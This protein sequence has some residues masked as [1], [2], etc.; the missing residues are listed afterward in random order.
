VWRYRKLIQLDSQTI[1]Q[2][3]LDVARALISVSSWDFIDKV[4]DIKVGNN[5]FVVRIIEERFGDI[6]L[7]FKREIDSQL[8]SD[9]SVSDNSNFDTDGFGRHGGA[10]KKNGGDWNEGWTEVNPGCQHQI[11]NYPTVNTAVDSDTSAKGVGERDIEVPVKG[12]D[13]TKEGMGTKAR[14]SQDEQVSKKKNEGE[15]V[16]GV[17][18]KGEE[19]GMLLSALTLVVGGEQTNL[20]IETSEEGEM[21]ARDLVTQ[22]HL[23][24]EDGPRETGCGL[25]QGSN[26]NEIIINKG[27]NIMLEE[28]EVAMKD[29]NLF[30]GSCSRKKYIGPDG[31]EVAWEEEYQVVKFL[32]D[33]EVAQLGFFHE[34]N[35][36]VQQNV[37]ETQNI[38]LVHKKQ[39]KGGG[40]G[41]I[42]NTSSMIAG[43]TKVERFAKAVH[44]GPRGR[45]NNKKSNGRATKP[46]HEVD[47][48]PI[49]SDS[50]G[51]DAQL[52][53]G[54]GPV[55]PVLSLEVVLFEAESRKNND[56]EIRLYRICW[57]MP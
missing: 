56:D 26:I 30:K 8:F 2:D 3:R 4:I 43:L 29:I 12:N 36:F 14:G 48:D 55:I 11:E 23:L 24:S 57:N 44:D 45:K 39:K 32:K 20:L 38:P 21:E 27:K 13:Q 40:G 7:G 28:D 22:Q 10:K 16:G 5:L 47:E 52:V 31:L 53:N 34:N 6:N 15:E 35:L 18:E 9:G 50:A 49:C 17:Q 19:R 41:V 42:H 46:T 1:N 51:S 54:Q 33:V 25:G 37:P